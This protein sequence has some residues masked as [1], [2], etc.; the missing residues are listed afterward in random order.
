MTCPLTVSEREVLARL[1]D[2]LH[3]KQVAAGR[4]SRHSTV[5]QHLANARRKL[6][7]SSTLAACVLFLRSGW[8]PDHPGVP[9]PADQAPAWY[10]LA[11]DEFLAHPFDHAAYARWR[12]AWLELKW[13]LEPGAFKRRLDGS[14]G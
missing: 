6:G 7:A 2:G 8:H 9:L 1:C 5:L 10:V 13:L 12:V 4:R 3:P 11:R 14:V